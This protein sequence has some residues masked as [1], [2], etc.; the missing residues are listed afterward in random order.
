MDNGE[1]GAQT[2]GGKNTSIL[3]SGHCRES[4]PRG[5][6]TGMSSLSP[7]TPL[8]L[9]LTLL[10]GKER[11][12]MRGG[13]TFFMESGPLSQGGEA[14]TLTMRASVFDECG[15]AWP[16]QATCSGV[17][18]SKTNATEKRC[19]FREKYAL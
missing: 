10:R 2:L 17:Q 5:I 8:F 12:G 3:F 19:S 13:A 4:E 16:W 14:R 7:A 6:W 1:Y 9:H 15:F 18:H 11:R